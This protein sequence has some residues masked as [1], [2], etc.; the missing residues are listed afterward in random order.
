[1]CYCAYVLEIIFVVSLAEGAWSRLVV[2]VRWRRE[3]PLLVERL[4]A[5]VCGSNEDR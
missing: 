2:H 4:R 5:V 1:M 3:D